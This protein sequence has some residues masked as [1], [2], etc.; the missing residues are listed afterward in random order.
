MLTF[1]TK[2]RKVNTGFSHCKFC[3]KNLYAQ[4]YVTYILPK[5]KNY[6]DKYHSLCLICKRVYYFSDEEAQRYFIS[7]YTFFEEIKEIVK[8]GIIFEHLK[9]TLYY[10]YKKFNLKLKKLL[11]GFK[12]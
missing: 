11:K 12:K 2:V 1:G 3:K 9:S 8:D 7:N 10:K 5:N 6:P 4:I